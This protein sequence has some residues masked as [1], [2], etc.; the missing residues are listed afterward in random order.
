MRK[1][2]FLGTFC[3]GLTFVAL[4][5]SNS[6]KTELT[7]QAAADLLAK[8][9]ID[10]ASM[11]QSAGGRACNC[12]DSVNKAAKN[13]SQQL[14]AAAGC[15]DAEVSSYQLSLQLLKAMKD[16]GNTRTITMT[17]NKNSDAYKLSYY[18]LERWLNDSCEV[19]RS[20]IRTNDEANE[21]SF[22][23]NPDAYAAYKEG[24]DWL[25]T[26]NYKEATPWFEKAVRLDPQFVFAW[27]NLG[28]CY[29]QTGELE[30]A[31]EAYLA[32]L[33]VD[34]AGHTALQ[35]L[36]VVYLK[37]K[38]SQEAINAYQAFLKQ[39]PGD[40]E[41]YYGIGLVYYQNLQDM[42][43]ALDNICKAYNIYVSQKSPYRS[44]AEKLIQSI[45]REMKNN[46]KEDVFNK[47]LKENNIRAN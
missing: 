44:D 25:K 13:K 3:F 7:G 23:K 46:N 1:F 37:Q 39:Y 15:I 10:S 11:L 35:N 19:L 26:Q 36:P 12:I 6:E 2:I 20:M 32:S 18:Q 33:K 41:V 24:V 47:I 27:D 4:S 45:Y 40:P 28:I 29:R 43:K 14:A 22:S 31:E 38:K 42:E 16:P 30:K 17:A 21:K 9:P 8:L 5:Q 34:P